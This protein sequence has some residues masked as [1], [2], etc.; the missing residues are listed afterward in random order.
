MR[1][2]LLVN[3]RQGWT[4]FDVVNFCKR[5]FG[6]REIGHL[7]TLDPMATGVL[8]VTVGSATKLFD[9]FLN[10]TKTYVAEFTFG[11]ST[12]TLDAEGQVE[13]KCDIIPTLEQIQQVL[14]A[15]IG[16]IEQMPPK[17]SAKKINGKKAYD[18][19]R[20][21]KDFELKPSKVTIHNLKILDYS[22]G[23]LK[24]EIECGAGTY[25]RSL[26]R[27][28]ALKL[29]SLATMT[30]LV[31]TKLGAWNIEDCI[32]VKDNTNEFIMSKLLPIDSVFN[33]L[34]TLDDVEMVKRLL[35]GQTVVVDIKDGDYRLY[36]D[37][38]FVAIATA[39]D[40]HIKMSKYFK[41]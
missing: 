2:I 12:D 25:I 19:A 28:I 29:N 34:S 6:T 18:L 9:M 37:N 39:K 15:F 24:L 14:P 30:S 3:K 35:N 7:G 16:E 5:V 22:N 4:S 38:G 33:N 21:G 27:D 31:R 26:G 36:K 13:N 8:A 32:D 11:Y 40:K 23:V 17:Y 41:I 20:S 10:K 1:G